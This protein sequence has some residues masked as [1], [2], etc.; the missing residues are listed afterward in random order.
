MMSP[1][2]VPA[3]LLDR[4]LILRTMPYTLPEAIQILAIRAQVRG[5]LL[6]TTLGCMPRAARQILTHK[7]SSSE[8]CQCYPR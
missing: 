2:G 6:F 4:L 7:V 1:H 8:G 3:D 5:L